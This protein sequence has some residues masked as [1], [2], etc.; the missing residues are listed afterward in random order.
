MS[1]VKVI[2]MEYG[3]VIFQCEREPDGFMCDLDGEICEGC[4]VEASILSDTKRRAGP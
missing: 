3:Q 2:Y 1:E 4:E